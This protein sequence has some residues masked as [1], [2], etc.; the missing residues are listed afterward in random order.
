MAKLNDVNTRDIADAIRV[1]CRAMCNLFNA[2]DNDIPFFSVIARPAA[3]ISMSMESHVPGRHLNA[4]LN[5][6]DAVGVEVDEECIAKHARAAFFSYGGPAALPLGRTGDGDTPTML[7]PH[8]VREGFHALYALVK[9]RGSEP[10][11]ELAEASIGLILDYWASGDLDYGRLERD[12]GLS[13]RHARTLISGLARSIGPLVKY[14]RATGYGRALELAI[15]LK[16]RVVNEFFLEDGAY[17]HDS[18]GTHCHSTT[19]VMSSLVQL[20]DLTTDSTL[21]SRTKAFYDNG[22]WQIRDELRME[23]REQPAGGQHRMR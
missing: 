10:A 9:Y 1:G 4:L 12:Y 2:D 5:A 17:D 15:L 3:E 19:G 11:R 22:L 23:H 13:F 14:Y 6:E 21:M 8:D 18:L 20:A 16:E 7:S